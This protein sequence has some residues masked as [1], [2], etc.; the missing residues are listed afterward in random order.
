[1]LKEASLVSNA[2]IPIWV[3]ST[4]PSIVNGILAG[5]MLGALSMF[6]SEVTGQG[7]EIC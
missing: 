7:T 4:G 5:A 1:M 2:G 3:K 6:S